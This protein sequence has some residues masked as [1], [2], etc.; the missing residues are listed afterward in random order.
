MGQFRVRIEVGDLQGI[1]FEPVDAL[2][3]T[4]ASDTRVPG[5]VLQRLGVSPQER[6]PF[7]I[8]DESIV[9][10]EIGQAM[11]C[12]D[13]RTRYTVVV[14]GPEASESLLG[15]TTLEAFGLGVD[16]VGRRLIPVPRL[17]M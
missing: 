10:Y 4:G 1:R 2:V 17:L 6:A 11:V 15:A 8:A 16:P 5:S 7:R 12:L 9:E 3:D 13:G 14:F